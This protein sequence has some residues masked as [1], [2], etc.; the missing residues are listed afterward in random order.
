MLPTRLG[1]WLSGL[2]GGLERAG[3]ALLDFFFF[4]F[5]APGMEIYNAS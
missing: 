5:F 2:G 4:F 3:A 1:S